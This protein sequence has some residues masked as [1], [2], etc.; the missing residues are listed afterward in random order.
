MCTMSLWSA[1]AVSRPIQHYTVDI[2]FQNV[3]LYIL[4]MMSQQPLDNIAMLSQHCQDTL[5]KHNA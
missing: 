3:I 4:R 1:L 2:F 5:L